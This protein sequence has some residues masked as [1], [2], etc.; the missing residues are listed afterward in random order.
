MLLIFASQDPAT[1][2]LNTPE[3]CWTTHCCL[4]QG[5]YVGRCAVGQVYM[6]AD[7]CSLT[8][9]S[10]SMII[11]CTVHL[12]FPDQLCHLQGSILGLGA[13]RHPSLHVSCREDSLHDC[14]ILFCGHNF[15]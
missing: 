12:C 5:C 2:P 7:G 13:R 11:S 10:A 1:E 9:L 4:T 3:S 15:A 6:Q 14:Q 8:H